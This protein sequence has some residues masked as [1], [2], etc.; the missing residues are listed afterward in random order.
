MQGIRFWHDAGWDG[1]KKFLIDQLRFLMSGLMDSKELARQLTQWLAA[2]GTFRLCFVSEIAT[3]I[4]HTDC[5]HG[6][7]VSYHCSVHAV[8][9]K[10]A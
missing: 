10:F 9:N 2:S 3:T 8:E 6:R 5:M 4:V 1:F 7:L